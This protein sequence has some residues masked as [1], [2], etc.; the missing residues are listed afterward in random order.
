MNHTTKQQGTVVR[1]FSQLKGQRVRLT[2]VLLSIIIYV[3]LSIWN[4]SGHRPSVAEHP[5][6]LEGRHAVC[7]QLD[8]HGP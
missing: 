1:L 5:G 2:V 6:G 7:H 4:P 8:Q 3:G